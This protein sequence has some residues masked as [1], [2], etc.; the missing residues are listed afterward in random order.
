MN[1]KM[2]K[3]MMVL[4][5]AVML[6]A[7]MALPTLADDPD[8]SPAQ[9][10]ALPTPMPPAILLTTEPFSVNSGTTFP[11][12]GSQVFVAGQPIVVALPYAVGETWRLTG[13]FT[14]RN[15]H[16]VHALDFQ[17]NTCKPGRVL[18][19][20]SGKVVAHPTSTCIKIDRGDGI[21]LGYQHLAPDD[22]VK[23]NAG[24]LIQRG[25][26]LGMT[27]F[28]SGCGGTTDGNLVH[29][30][31][32]GTAKFD[33][34]TI[35][36]GYTVVS[37]LC[38]TGE[39]FYK[40]GIKYCPWQP[41]WE[42]KNSGDA[43][44]PPSNLTVTDVGGG[45]VQLD[46]ND[47]SDNENGFRAY[48]GSNLVA[49]VVRNQDWTMVKV[50]GAG[51]HCYSVSAYNDNGESAKSPQACFTMLPNPNN[52]FQK[53]VSSLWQ[54]QSWGRANLTV[55]ADNLNGKTVYARFFRTENG[56][57]NGKVTREWK[58]SKRATSGCVIFWDMD[59]AGPL[60][61]N[62]RYFSQAA[63]EQEPNPSWQ[64]PNCAGPTAGQ[65]LCDSIYRP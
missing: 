63:L 26:F 46:W 4:V 41:N 23:F 29:F 39:A 60:L 18:A 62:T 36:G 44:I 54:D 40:N 12:L 50:N 49:N 58:Y 31:A 25:Q 6:T 11:Q 53:G 51:T 65:G 28:Q 38:G 48:D 20:A 30:W 34:G 32:E 47:N 7:T 17:T 3:L 2:W 35:I 57:Y 27:T 13:N 64:A 56:Q 10:L 33:V 22:L 9:P 45:Y 43:P 5:L 55:C 15:H 52:V 14:A 42:F 1:A 37:E 24:D 59:G 16:A 61:R 21:I 8:V 19:A